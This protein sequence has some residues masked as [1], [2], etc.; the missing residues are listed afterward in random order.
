MI[1]AYLRTSTDRQDLGLSAQRDA[2][3]RWAESKG[4]TIG[5]W[6]AEQI[7]GSVRPHKRPE[8]GA[9]LERL[10]AGDTLVVSR[11]D[12]LARSLVG[13]A[14][15]LEAAHSCGWTLVVLDPALDTTTPY[16][17]TL[18][19]VAGAFAELERELI[20]QRTREA[21]R[22]RKERG[23]LVRRTGAQH[24]RY[25]IPPR[26]ADALFEEA[27]RQP[28]L[29]WQ[30]LAQ[31]LT[32]ARIPPPSPSGWTARAAAQ[33]C[34]RWGVARGLGRPPRRKVE[35][36]LDPHRLRGVL[37]VTHSTH[38]PTAHTV[39]SA[40]VLPPKARPGA[41][42]ERLPDGRVVHWADF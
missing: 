24:P 22:A 30:Q 8:F 13:L 1:R 38:P 5:E 40:I 37:Q 20:R 18:A 35:R 33:M 21:L 2:I 39:E 28:L 10:E 29:S 26:E 31:Q 11:L 9:L 15:I 41:R 4:L 16:G 42:A 7:S 17:R 3:E 23:E 12:R 32:A 34:A 25:W 27:Y 14:E 36:Q 6:T 19:Q